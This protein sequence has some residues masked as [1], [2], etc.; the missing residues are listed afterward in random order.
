MTHPTEPTT[1][2]LQE[3]DQ[4]QQQQQQQQQ[5]K[6][7]PC[8]H[9]STTPSE[10][11]SSALPTNTDNTDDQVHSIKLIGHIKGVPRHH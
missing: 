9:T 2:P 4:V 8:A 10:T 7:E 6:Q 11:V 1:V 5:Q 3:Q